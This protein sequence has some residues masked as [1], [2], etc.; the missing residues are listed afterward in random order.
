MEGKINLELSEHKV[1]KISLY[2]AVLFS[3]MGVALG[4]V[5]ESQIIVFDGLYSMISVL[6][7]GISIATVKFKNKRDVKRYPFGKDTVEPLVIILKYSVILLLV[8][9]SFASAVKSAFSGGREIE[10]GMAL[11]YSVISTFGCYAFYRYIKL[12]SIKKG[13]GLIS[14]ESNQ[15]LMDTLVSGGVFFG[16]IIAYLLGKVS[17]LSW[18]T[19]YID[20]AMVI[21][22]SVYFVKVPV[23][24][25]RKSMRELLDMAPEDDLGK[26]VEKMVNEIEV[27]Y[28][29]EETFLRVS[30][31][32]TTL[33][34]EV[35]FVV[36]E[37]SSIETIED[38]DEIRE[39]I[40]MGINKLGYDK[41]LTVSFTND[42]K[43]A[44]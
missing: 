12:Y 36:G 43:W 2:G 29:M 1:L 20:P 11:I 28:D 27:K 41:W 32:S 23:A 4:V 37:N 25:I 33:W 15:W 35:D 13:S 10:I 3:L 31:V 40:D 18:I 9:V 16:F 14:A 44:I 5:S 6:L 22:I 17:S 42:R 7:S 24:E 38:Q 34:V 26:N 39:E 19:P 8:S 21:V 30:V